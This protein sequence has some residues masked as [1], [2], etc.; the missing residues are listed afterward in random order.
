[1]ADF[2]NTFVNKNILIYGLGKS[3]LSSLNFLKKNNKINLYDD[4]KKIFYSKKNKKLSIEFK[5]IFKKKFDFIVISPGIDIN[6]C[7]LKSY[8]KK[9][10]SKIVTDL[11]IFY[12][13]YYNN[14]N[15]AITGT[16]GKST[17]AKILFEILK[18]EKK[19]VR[20][21]GN[22]GNPILLEKNIN[23][24]TIFVIEASS[25]QIEY[26]KKFKANYAMIINISP[27]HLERHG[28][29]N[30]Y[31]KSKFK[32]IK[33]QNKNNYSFL[34]TDNKY[35]KKCIVKSRLKSKIIKVNNKITKQ[36]LAKISNSYFLT[37]G[38]QQNLSFV[39]AISKILKFKKKNIFKSINNFKCLK[40]RQQIIYKSKNITIIND[41]K[42]TSFSSSVNVL[43]SL[44]KVYW[45]VGGIPKMHD[46]FL[47]KKKECSNFKAYIF[48]KNK[49]YFIHQFKN[50]TNYE[51]FENLEKALKKIILDI[52]N[53]KLYVHRNILF[54]PSAAS[55]DTFKNFEDRGIKFNYLIQKTK[56]KNLIRV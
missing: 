9:N 32:L 1:M 53:E 28:S 10:K 49:R 20:L 26:S 5:N 22:I 35:L 45:L 3:G 16:N 8:I 2:K 46:K 25:Y 52:N 24:K 6:K 12:S 13:N 30:N 48:G 51:C 29:F 19:D 37:E 44:Q 50:K 17:T 11:D 47:M 42:A 38:N 15:I 34:D 54:S 4:D 55:F 23:H 40:F 21:T 14:K 31:V 27:D 36:N 56:I 43:K 33:N 18:N 7:N 39:F 41:S